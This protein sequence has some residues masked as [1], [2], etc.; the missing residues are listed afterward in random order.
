MTLPHL[1]PLPDHEDVVAIRDDVAQLQECLIEAKRRAEQIK[2]AAERLE[3]LIVGT[4][5]YRRSLVQV[6][7]V[8][9]AMTNLDRAVMW[10]V[11]AAT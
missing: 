9:L 10:A 4:E 6:R 11:K 7:H 2:D 3:A 1:E 8:R 5:H